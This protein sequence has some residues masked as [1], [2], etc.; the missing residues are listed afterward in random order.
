[1]LLAASLV[2]SEATTL[3]AQSEP[4]FV[5]DVRPILRA[6][7]YSC[8]A[9]RKQKSGLRLDIKAFA[10]RGGEG[11][12]PSIIPHDPDNSPLWKRISSSDLD[13]RMPPDGPGL[14]EN[15]RTIL[16]DW[17]I[18][19][20][21]WPDGVDDASLADPKS[22]WA[23]QPLRSFEGIHSIDSWI[24]KSLNEHGLEFSPPASPEQWLRRVTLDLHG[25]P[26]SPEELD[27][28]LTDPSEAMMEQVVDRLLDSPRYGE[29]WAQ[30]W[31]DVV[32]YADTHGFEVNTERPHAWHYRDYVIDA[33]NR[34]TSY[35]RFIK[36][37]IAGD[38]LG[39]DTATGFLITAS[40]LLPGQI[41]ADEPSKRL[42][43]QDAI[44]EIVV[45]IGQTF[46]GLTIGCARCHDHKF[47]PITQEDYYAMQAFVAGIEYG[48][49]IVSTPRSE[50]LK[51]EVESLTV[52][53]QNIDDQLSRLEPIADPNPPDPSPPNAV[54]NEVVFDPLS[55]KWIRLEIF[56][57]N[58]HPSLGKIEPCIDELEVWTDE[59]TPQNVAL[60]TLGTRASA[61]GSRESDRHRLSH[62]NDG[63]YG[64][65]H[66]WMSDANGRGWVLLELPETKRISKIVWGRDREGQFQ[67]RLATAY[68]ISAGES[69]SSMRALAA[70]GLRRSAV[71]AKLNQE[72]ISP[73]LA[74]RLRLSIQA[75]NNLEPCIDELEVINIDGI[76]IALA[77]H[78]TT[79]TSS[80][81]TI[82]ADRHDLRYVN[83]GRY[84]NQ[85]S[86]M[87]NEVG[88]GMLTLEFPKPEMVSRIVWGRD[89]ESQFTDRLPIEYQIELEDTDGHWSVIAGSMDRQPYRD[90]NAGQAYI[91]LGFEDQETANRLERERKDLIHR[92]NAATDAQKAFAGIFRKPDAI[93]VLY[94]GDPEQPRDA[95]SPA[96]PGFLGAMVL[97]QDSM[98]QQ[99]RTVLADW[100][101][102]P[103]NPFTARVMVNRIWHGHFGAGLV[104]TPN[105]FGL[106]GSLPSHP[107][108]LDWLARQWWDQSRW[109]MKWL[110]KQIV[111]SRTYRQSSSPR[112]DALRIDA[113][114]K[115]LWRYPRRRMESESIRDAMLL[116]SGR[117][118]LKMYGR[119]F[120]LFD[121]RGG[122]SGF[123]PVESY[124]DDGLRRMVY[125]HKVRR[126]REAVFGAFD[127]PDAGQSAAARRVSTTPIQALNL[128]NSVF[129]LEQSEAF[130]QR[131]RSLAGDDIPSQIRTAYRL[132]LA[133]PAREDEVAEAMP[134][135]HIHGLAV[136]CRSLFNSSE[137]LFLP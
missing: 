10:M 62:I 122:L 46:L 119:G 78:G 109:S 127:C 29:R 75:T 100:I 124:R 92:R 136:L 5:L 15:V 2:L 14:S 95:V 132:A 58:L 11:D 91:G 17:I 104:S 69:P 65:S 40:V 26:P 60:A 105:D 27:T 1:M 90:G 103:D 135:V 82:V 45:N 39:Q 55:A 86:W 113:D 131:V 89:R 38:A 102:S 34:D 114:A 117:L 49:R 111:L 3:C 37:Q 81:D 101:A 51:Q 50:S 16:R 53:L 128:F 59:P 67:D 63:L 7:C 43:R 48:D 88:K 108:L 130:A 125:A 94:R 80:G 112:A 42:A 61:S 85:R 123:R 6:H 23:F 129:T 68:R 74:K 71:N 121:L 98:E 72:K 83:D 106:N 120:D 133:R 33:L 12:G 35:D 76:N 25:L 77:T 56:D 134:E 31:L 47:D 21:G 28:F 24:E 70:E 96:V 64:N 107:E 73:T 9:E 116:V 115:W 36:E 44:D 66:S 13:E 4:D 137:F 54:R 99:R 18:A 30:H 118:N 41:G 8:H 87:S 22:H 20:A 52:S 126:E 97:E 57:T 93:H 84:G 110:H 19:G 79:V 32:R